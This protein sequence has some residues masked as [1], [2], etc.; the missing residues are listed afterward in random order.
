VLG[1]SSGGRMIALS[2]DGTHLALT[3]LGTDTK[4][5]LATR[6]LHENQATILRGTEGASYPFFSPDGKRDGKRLAYSLLNGTGSDI[7]VKDLERDTP[8]KLT[9]FPQANG[10]PVWTP[11]GQYIIFRSDNT[12]APGLYIVRADGSSEPQRLTQDR[13]GVTENRLGNCRIRFLPMVSVWHT[14][15]PDQEAA[16]AC[17]RLRWNPGR[18]ETQVRSGSGNRR[19]LPGHSQTKCILHSRRTTGG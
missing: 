8:S 6:L 3:L 1:R 2:A 4:V 12:A 15:Q 7:W 11:D 13:V 18:P 5:R 16:M 10:W 19:P 17:L 14:P 9:S